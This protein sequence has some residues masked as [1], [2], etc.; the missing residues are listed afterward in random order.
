MAAGDAPFRFEPAWGRAF[1]AP[2]GWREL[3]YRSMMDEARR[4]KR[5]MSMMWL[6]RFLG[7]ISS[8]KKQA[9]FRR[10]SGVVL[11]ERE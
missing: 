7:R 6:W 10:M 9:E 3:S 11:L 5:E 2:Y 8:A 1:F 4:L